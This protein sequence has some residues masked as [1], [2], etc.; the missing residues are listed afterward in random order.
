MTSNPIAQKQWEPGGGG[1]LSI[2]FLLL[3]WIIIFYHVF[4]PMKVSWVGRFVLLILYT[5]IYTVLPC[6]SLERS[7]SPVSP[8]VCF[9]S[10]WK[11]RSG[12]SHLNAF[13][14]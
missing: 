1:C 13:Y 8:L 9:E 4:K 11:D 14:S 10:C 2:M 5:I 6:H 7:E 12:W 3:P